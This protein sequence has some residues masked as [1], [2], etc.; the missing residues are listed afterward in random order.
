MTAILTGTEQVPYAA[1]ANLRM[2]LIATDIGTV[3][4]AALTFGMAAWRHF[5]LQCAGF[6]MHCC[7]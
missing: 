5:D 4:P 1:A 3:V 6:F 2:Q 7:T